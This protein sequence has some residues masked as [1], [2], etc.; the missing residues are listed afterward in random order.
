MVFIVVRSKLCTTHII[1]R[2]IDED[3][4]REMYANRIL[5]ISVPESGFS[6]LHVDTT[7][8]YPKREKAPNS[9]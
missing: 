3:I 6:R 5:A 8:V 1:V 7:Q 4:T 2:R 9:K